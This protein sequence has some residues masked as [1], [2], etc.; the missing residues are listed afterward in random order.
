[1][2]LKKPSRAISGLVVHFVRSH[3]REKITKLCM[4]ESTLDA[5]L[6]S[7]NTVKKLSHKNVTNISMKE[8]TQEKSHSGATIVTKGSHEYT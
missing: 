3:S 7:A 6:I 5:S 4:K 2:V 1:M 8:R